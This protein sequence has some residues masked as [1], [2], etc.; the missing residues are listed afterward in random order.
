[1]NAGLWLTSITTETA[2]VDKPTNAEETGMVTATG[3]SISTNRSAA[4]LL[5]TT[6]PLDGVPES[7]WA[8]AVFEFQGA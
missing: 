4:S 2:V 1:M 8:R 5:T 6:E 7:S 3:T